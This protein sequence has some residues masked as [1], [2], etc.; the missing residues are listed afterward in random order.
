MPIMSSSKD[1]AGRDASDA[2]PPTPSVSSRVRL[3]VEIL[4]ADRAAATQ[5]ISVST[6]AGTRRSVLVVAGETDVR[7]YVRECLRERTDLRVIEA[8]SVTSA[9]LL[10]TSDA[11]DFM[12][13]DDPERDVARLLPHVR[14]II[15]VDDVPAGGAT[16]AGR[17]RL[18]VRPFAAG[19]LVAEVSR[20]LSETAVDVTR[21]SDP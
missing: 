2:A 9:V 14:V 16:L 10:A 11:P 5:P 20:L 21:I 1:G 13:A 7:R 3:E 17:I 19:V 6:D 4:D 12:I 8:D 18:L 15:I